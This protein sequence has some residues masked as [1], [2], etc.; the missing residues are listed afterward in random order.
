ME[1][2]ADAR[3]PISSVLLTL[4]RAFKSP[5]ETE[6]AILASAVMGLVSDLAINAVIMDMIT[7]VLNT[8][9]ILVRICC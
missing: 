4:A 5:C 9:I 2:K 3:T 8:K 7:N 1:L 6:S